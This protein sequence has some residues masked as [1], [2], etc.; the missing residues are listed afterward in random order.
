[1]RLVIDSTDGANVDLDTMVPP[2]N[3]HVLKDSMEINVYRN[4]IVKTH[5]IAIM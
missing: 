3:H 1:M 5:W 4:V 2:V